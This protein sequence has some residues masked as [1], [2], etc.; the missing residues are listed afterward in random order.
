[1]T[2]NFENLILEHLKRFQSSLDRMERR[3]D[4]MAVRLSNLESAYASIMQHLPHLAVADAAQQVV[5]DN[6]SMRVDRIERR[7]ELTH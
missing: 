1:M 4:E 3:M 7:L 6:I 2:D 5:I